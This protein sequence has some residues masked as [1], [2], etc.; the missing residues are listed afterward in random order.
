VTQSDLFQSAEPLRAAQS[1]LFQS[2]EALR[3]TQ[4]DL[5]QAAEAFRATHIARAPPASWPSAML[6]GGAG[7]LD[8]ILEVVFELL[9]ADSKNRGLGPRLRRPRTAR[10]LR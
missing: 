10:R 4:S 1:D 5:F 8:A 7:T 2:A 3:A 9:F 6:A